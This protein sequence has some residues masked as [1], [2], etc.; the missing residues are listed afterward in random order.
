[1]LRSTKWGMLLSLDDTV[2]DLLSALEKKAKPLGKIGACVLSLGQ[3]L[4]LTK[5]Y[6]VSSQQ[7][8]DFKID[9]RALIPILTSADG[10]PFEVRKTS[11]QLVNASALTK[12][13]IKVLAA[14]GIRTFDLTSTS[15]QPPILIMPR[16][17]GRHYCA[18]NSAKAFSSSYVD[19]Y[20]NPTRPNDETVYSLW[21]ILNSSV[22]WLLREAA[23]RKNLGGGML[24]AE[25][26]DLKEIPLFMPLSHQSEIKRLAS[27]MRDRDA[28]DTVSEIETKE[29]RAIDEIVFEHLGLSL[30][31]QT[32]VVDS[33]RQ[34]IIDRMSKSET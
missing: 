5:D 30:K 13:E 4:N 19:V 12:H 17:I 29:H 11:Q 9:S 16:G 10:A 34:K 6:Y 24:K 7:Q 31:Q 8:H 18:I 2:L 3:G 28:L 21:V 22:A 26:V 14:A 33:L 23:G 1:M 32:L 15:K 25:A 27:Q 20:S